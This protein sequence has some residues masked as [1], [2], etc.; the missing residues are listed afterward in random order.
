M[1]SRNYYVF[2]LVFYALYSCCCCWLC[3]CFQFYLIGC[4]CF[5]RFSARCLLCITLIFS[6]SHMQLDLI[7]LICSGFF[8]VVS[9]HYVWLWLHISV[10]L[11]FF[12]L[13]SSRK[14]II[15]WTDERDMCVQDEDNTNFDHWVMFTLPQ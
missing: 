4:I 9:R 7:L 5:C 15:L 1:K 12:S 6:V 14:L 8:A 13:A 2:F 3:F 11:L 10:I